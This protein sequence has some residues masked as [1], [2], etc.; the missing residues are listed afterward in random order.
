MEGIPFISMLRKFIPII[1]S[2]LY[3]KGM[4]LFIFSLMIDLFIF[5]I[6]R[7][8]FAPIE[9]ELRDLKENI[10]EATKRKDLND[11]NQA[12][13]ELKKETNRWVWKNLSI[14]MWI[15][16]GIISVV[17]SILF[18]TFSEGFLFKYPLVL[19]LFLLSSIVISCLS[20]IYWVS[21]NHYL[22]NIKRNLE[23]VKKTYQK[24]ERRDRDK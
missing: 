4:I 8:Y 16:P 18:K 13:E 9:N 12:L 21:F 14:I 11:I 1:K 17:I 20:I 24:K 15:F 7:L 3:Y 2:S 23:D 22:K 6:R 5:L 10:K 19:V